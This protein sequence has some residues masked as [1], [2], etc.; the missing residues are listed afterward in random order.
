MP[1]FYAD[2]TTLYEIRKSKEEIERKLQDAS[3]AILKVAS[4]CKQNGTVINI[5]KTKAML[6]TTW[7]RKSRI[8]DNIQIHV[9]HNNVQLINVR[10][11]DKLLFRMSTVLVHL[12]KKGVTRN[13]KEY[14]LN[15]I[16]NVLHVCKNK[17]AFSL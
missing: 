1:D 6:I 13:F 17:K 14:S 15:A 5:D 16:N 2:D 11:L 9:S 7:Q 8:D 10:A 3:D 12:K 4:W